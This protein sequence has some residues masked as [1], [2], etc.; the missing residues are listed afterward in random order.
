[1][2]RGMLRATLTADDLTRLTTETLW[3]VLLVSAPALVASLAIG[4]AV[5]LL[6]A[7]TQI[8]DQTLSFVPKLVVVAITLVIFGSFMGEEIVR[9][10]Q[11][12]WLEIPRLV[13]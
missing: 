5:G 1:M 9:F 2:L 11:T 7:A 8:Q 13:G 6:Q 12:L 3:L 4:L 10:T